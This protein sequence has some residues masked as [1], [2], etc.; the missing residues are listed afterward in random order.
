M[1]V[2]NGRGES[3]EGDTLPLLVGGTLATTDIKSAR[4]FYEEFLGLDCV[5][6]GPKQL[7]LR[8]QK[9]KQEM[10]AGGTYFFVLEVTEV[11][12]IGRQQVPLNHWG[13][14]VDRQEE[15]DRIRAAAIDRTDEFGIQKVMPITGLHG[16]YGFFLADRDMNWWEIEYR[17]HGRTNNM[18]FDEGDAI[19]DA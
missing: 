4:K 11:D 16:A 8:D 14:T 3:V 17:T 13:I 15:V 19:A 1:L 12:E 2:S 18:V 5:S 9:S 6:H 7:L 10:E